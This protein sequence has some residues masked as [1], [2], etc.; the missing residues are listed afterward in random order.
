MVE[1][2][3]L[4]GQIVHSAFF[5]VIFACEIPSKVFQCSQENNVVESSIIDTPYPSASWGSWNQSQLTSGKSQGKPWT[6][7]NLLQD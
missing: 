2:S 1:C 4:I 6:T 3:N 7:N 5:T